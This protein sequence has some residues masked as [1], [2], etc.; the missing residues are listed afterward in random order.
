M[1]FSR[2]GQQ[3]F[4]FFPTGKADESPL[5]LATER[6]DIASGRTVP[7]AVKPEDVFVFFT[8]PFPH[9]LGNNTLCFQALGRVRR[10]GSRRLNFPRA[11]E[12]TASMPF[13]PWARLSPDGKTCG[14]IHWLL[15]SEEPHRPV[16]VGFWNFDDGADRRT[17]EL[18]PS[19]E[20]P[21]AVF[22]PDSRCLLCTAGSGGRS[23]YL[24]D[25]K[26]AKICSSYLAAA[27]MR[28]LFSINSGEVAAVSVGPKSVLIYKI[29][30]P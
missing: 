22:T 1:K 5:V 25:V 21:T 11:S 4:A 9:V 19:D 18:P 13:T 15:M 3:L 7:C 23:I 27:P 2:D 29:P 30:K 17:V 8:G 6:W 12:S 26:T 16:T 14:D 20:L 10:R 28:G 24:V